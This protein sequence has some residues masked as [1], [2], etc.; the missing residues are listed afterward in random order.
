MIT[1][2]EGSTTV[3]DVSIVEAT[4]V[5]KEDEAELS[6]PEETKD[7]IVLVVENNDVVSLKVS[8]E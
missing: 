5:V 8:N 7:G 6:I 1:V 2:E 3:D 4:S